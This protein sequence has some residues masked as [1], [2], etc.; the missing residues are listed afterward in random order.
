MQ[1]GKKDEG[2]WER[3]KEEVERRDY[4]SLQGREKIKKKNYMYRPALFSRPKI[5]LSA[6]KQWEMLFRKEA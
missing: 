3:K 4:L 2:Y 6:W 5:N 1:F